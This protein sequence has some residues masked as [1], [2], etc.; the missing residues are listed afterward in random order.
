MSDKMLVDRLKE[1]EQAGLVKR[2]V[3]PETPV[4]IEYH[5]TDKGKAIEPALDEVQT[6]AENWMS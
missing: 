6:W 2:S 3:F 4:R 5:L 1:L